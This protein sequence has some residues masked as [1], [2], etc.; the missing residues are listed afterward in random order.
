M[1]TEFFRTRDGETVTITHFFV[2]S[3][4]QGY[5]FSA[6]FDVEKAAIFVYGGSG[7]WLSMPRAVADEIRAN[8]PDAEAKAVAFVRR[9]FPNSVA[10][11][12]KVAS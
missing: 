10:P 1:N 4:Y 12:P 7:V 5:K 9:R 8:G 11:A 2:E 6:K 3:N